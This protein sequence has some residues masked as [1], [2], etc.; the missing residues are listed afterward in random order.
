[1]KDMYSYH[2]MPLEH[3]C[4]VCRQG[5]Q[6]T[7]CFEP[8]CDGG[9]PEALATSSVC[10]P[11]FAMTPASKHVGFVQNGEKKCW[12]NCWETADAACSWFGHLRRSDLVADAESGSQMHG[13]KPESNTLRSGGQQPCHLD[14][15]EQVR[16]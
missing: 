10:R 14:V 12:P 6:A 8:F 15:I 4:F 3:F 13:K 5:K 11:V 1:M 7:C 9:L 16:F 2:G